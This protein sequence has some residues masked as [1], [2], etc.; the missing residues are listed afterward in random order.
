MN[1]SPKIASLCNVS[2]RVPVLATKLY[3]PPVRHGLVP[4]PRLI[5][6]LSEGM[7]RKL[8]LISAPA[9]FGK[10]TLLSDWIHQG[11]MHVAWLSLDRSDNN[12]EDLLT[13]IVTALQTI[14][15]DIGRTV[16]TS[17][18]SP[19]KPTVESILT[20]M[21]NDIVPV[22]KD[23]VFVLDDYHLV[24]NRQIHDMTETELLQ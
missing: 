14:E 12:P 2:Q 10:T 18:Q 7:C 23:F 5:K 11:E 19:Q 20:Y 3:I 21:I 4:R 22:E 13:Y 15:A 17:L 16:L 6:Q 9:G 24:D 8:I 1:N